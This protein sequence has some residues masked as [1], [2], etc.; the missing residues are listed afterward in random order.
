MKD[1]TWTS[2]VLPVAL[3]RASWIRI[4]E[5][6]LVGLLVMVL[7]IPQPAFAQLGGLSGLFNVI[8]QAANSILNFINGTMRPLLQ[9]IQSAAQA[10]Q[11]FLTELQTLWEQIVWP[12]SEINRAHALAQQ[13]I[14]AFRALLNNLYSIGANSAQLPH[15]IQLEGVMRNHQVNDHAQLVTAF[16]QT[17]GALPAPADVHPEERNLIDADDALAVDQLMTLKM[18]DAAADQVIQAAQAIEDET[19]RTAPGTAAMVSAAAYIASVESQAYMQ[20]MIA[21]QLRQEAARLAHDTM[22]LKRGAS[23]ARDSRKN[24]TDL[25][26]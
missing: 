3:G 10:L 5:L 24:L 14:G 8:N 25:N 17:F 11:N 23:F 2:M 7:L 16:Q 12:I 13:L 20:K 4:L 26:R 1:K 21:G 9:G 19:T 18:A 6:G 15:A 22:A